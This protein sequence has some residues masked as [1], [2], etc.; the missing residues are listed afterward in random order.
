[1]LGDRAASYQWISVAIDNK[2]LAAT[3]HCYSVAYVY[4]RYISAKILYNN[5]VATLLSK[6]DIW[7]FIEV[8]LLDCEHFLNMSSLCNIYWYWIAQ[9][10][11]AKF[12]LSVR[13]IK[14]TTSWWARS[15]L[16][17]VF[18]RERREIH[19]LNSHD[20]RRKRIEEPKVSGSDIKIIFP[21]WELE[22]TSRRR[23]GSLKHGN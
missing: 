20:E 1:M 14:A 17:A 4:I 21:F 6:T 18:I 13:E 5:K 12:W 8:T 16:Y 23:R 19:K 2:R 22:N 15:F 9:Q 7:R 11:W 10:L 3:P